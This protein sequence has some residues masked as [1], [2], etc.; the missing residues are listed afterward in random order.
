MGFSGL[1]ADPPL[2][3]Q[4]QTEKGKKLSRRCCFYLSGGGALDCLVPLLFPSLFSPYLPLPQNPGKMSEREEIYI[5]FSLSSR[6]IVWPTLRI[7]DG[8][9]LYSVLYLDS[10]TAG[11][12]ASLRDSDTLN[13]SFESTFLSVNF[14]ICYGPTGCVSPILREFGCGRKSD[15]IIM[16]EGG[17]GGGESASKKM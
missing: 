13:E 17:A 3:S 11:Y 1:G 8:D 15:G 5:S 7:F 9:T 6:P 12:G 16:N 14:P 2:F 4:A 10:A